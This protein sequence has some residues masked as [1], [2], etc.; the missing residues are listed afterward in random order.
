MKNVDPT[1]TITEL[2]LP[3]TEKPLIIGTNAFKVDDLPADDPN[4]RVVTIVTS[5]PLLADYALNKNIQENFEAGKVKATVTAPNHYWT[6]SCG[7]DVLVPHGLSVYTCEMDNSEKV[8][9]TLITDTDLLV[10]G[11]CIIKANNGVLV[12]CADGT[13]VYDVVASSGNQVSGSTP[14]TY[15]AK[16][17]GPNNLLEPVI[18]SK[19]YNANDYLVLKDNEFH[20]ILDNASMVPACKAVL[21]KPKK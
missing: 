2:V 8:N 3:E 19:N 4:H 12:A 6:F 17:Y 1:V 16:S 9:K 18:V 20:P 11:K 21:R 14:V 13:N 7:V 10:N 5:L 15:D